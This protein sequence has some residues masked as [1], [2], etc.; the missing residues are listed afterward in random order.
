MLPF[1]CGNRS[2]QLGRRNIVRYSLFE[3]TDLFQALLAG[4]EFLLC[5]EQLFVR[6]SD[7]TRSRKDAFPLL[8]MT[9]VHCVIS[10][11]ICSACRVHHQKSSKGLD[12][13]IKS[14][15]NAS[16]SAHSNMSEGESSSLERYSF[17]RFQLLSLMRK[18][19]RHYFLKI[20]PREDRNGRRFF[21]RQAQR[22]SMRYGF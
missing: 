18:R 9:A 14:S 4:S 11:P 15:C 12:L 7:L 1:F 22:Y 5:L 19:I 6:K 17:F 13:Q 3:R 8:P 2:F 10:S 20:R 21:H 16:A